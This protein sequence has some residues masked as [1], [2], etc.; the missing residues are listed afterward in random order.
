MDTVQSETSASEGKKN[1]TFFQFT[2]CRWVRRGP[3]VGHL[4]L[5]RALGQ[6]LGLEVSHRSGSSS[7]RMR[8]MTTQQQDSQN[9]VGCEMFPCSDPP[10]SPRPP[11]PCTQGLTT[12]NTHT[13]AP[14]N[15]TDQH[16]CLVL[17]P[18]LFKSYSQSVDDILHDI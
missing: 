3:P 9:I 16:F 14:I 4:W 6:V 17:N 11:P 2:G 15:R 5:G 8:R 10:P 13:H 18:R 12:I 1:G 7:C